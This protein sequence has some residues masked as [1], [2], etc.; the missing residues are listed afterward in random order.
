MNSEALKKT[1]AVLHRDLSRA[2]KLEEQSRELLRQLLRDAEGLPPSSPAVA[3]IEERHRLEAL[4]VGF[5]A[6]HPDLAASL[7]QL[8]DLLVK[9]GM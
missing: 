6:E 3:P 5:E 8:M 4:A 1:L 2:P 9:A 7:R